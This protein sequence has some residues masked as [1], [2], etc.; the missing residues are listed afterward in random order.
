[1]I[2]KAISFRKRDLESPTRFKLKVGAVSLSL[3]KIKA[4][5][6]VKVIVRHLHTY[7]HLHLQLLISNN[8]KE[9]KKTVA[10]L[11]F[12][13]QFENF[14]YPYTLRCQNSCKPLCRYKKNA[15]I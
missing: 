12:E 1:M 7:L 2:K 6:K 14:K 8:L 9:K 10:Q 4:K 5:S 13:S 3:R 11:P 15:S